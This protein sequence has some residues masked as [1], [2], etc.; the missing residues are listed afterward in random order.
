MVKFAS[1]ASHCSASF[2]REQARRSRATSRSA[3]A[4]A[5]AFTFSLA[6]QLLWRITCTTAMCLA[7]ERMQP[8]PCIRTAASASVHRRR[9]GCRPHRRSCGL[10]W[11]DGTRYVRHAR[12]WHAYSVRTVLPSGTYST[13]EAGTCSSYVQPMG[14]TYQHRRAQ[15]RDEARLV[16]AAE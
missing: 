10:L 3:M 12:G 9:K 6:V 5:A 8:G 15:C 4:S 2:C 1:V 16:P 14:R 7:M 13:Q 11:C